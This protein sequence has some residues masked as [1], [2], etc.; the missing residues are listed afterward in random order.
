MESNVAITG[1]IGGAVI[2]LWQHRASNK[3]IHCVSLIYVAATCLA[4]LDFS[5]RP[6]V[7]VF[8]GFRELFTTCSFLC[9]IYAYFFCSCVSGDLCS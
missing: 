1:V 5:L 4:S 8:P 6:C 3:L 7:C 9:N 2:Y